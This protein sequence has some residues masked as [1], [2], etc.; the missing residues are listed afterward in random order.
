MM[1]SSKSK[2][3]F[4]WLS[5]YQIVA[6]LLFLTVIATGY[7]NCKATNDVKNVLSEMFALTIAVFD[8]SPISKNFLEY[9]YSNF[10]L[11]VPSYKTDRASKFFK[12][13]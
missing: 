6:I 13:C 7:T 11:P 10:S 9:T 3:S 4:I 5:K 12:I 2:S 1:I 8:F